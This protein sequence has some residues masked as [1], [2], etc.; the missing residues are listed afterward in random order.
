MLNFGRTP[1]YPLFIPDGSVDEGDRLHLLNL[2]SGISLSAVTPPVFSG[3]LSNLDVTTNS[4]KTID[5]SDYFTD[6]TSYSISPAV[7]SGWSFNTS[8]GAL[9]I[10]ETDVARYGAYTIT[11]T[12]SGG[13]A[14]S[15]EF[16]IHVRLGST[17]GSYRPT[18]I[19]KS[20]EE[21]EEEISLILKKEKAEAL[22]EK[23]SLKAK[24]DRLEVK[25]EREEKQNRQTQE[26]R[27]KYLIVSESLLQVEKDLAEI[28]KKRAEINLRARI[29]RDDDEVM[30]LLMSKGYV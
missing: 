20:V 24:E 16:Y 19:L 23:K 1:V 5:Y 10:L 18:H 8:T 7:E 14:D 13:S 17:G 26:T 4:E 28:T 27:L 12:N 22:K 11:G 29:M 21:Y 9:T 3:S 25:I 30:M 6:A 2:Y 15:N